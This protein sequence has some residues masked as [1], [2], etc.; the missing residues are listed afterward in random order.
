M[1]SMV[2]VSAKSRNGDAEPTEGL[3]DMKGTRVYL[4]EEQLIRER[5]VDIL[6]THFRL[7]GYR[8][9]ET[10]ILEFWDIA[11]SK[12]GGGSEIL[13]ETYKLSDQGKRDLALRYELT[14]KLGKV[15]GMNPEMRL[16]F[17]RYEIGK[18]FRDGPIKAGR[19][20]EFTQCDVDV[21]GIK[22]LSADAEL[23]AL[24]FQTFPVLGLEDIYM[25]LNNR[26]LLFGIF[27]YAV[28]PNEK[29]GEAALSL[30]KLAK[31]GEDK[32]RT[33]LFQKEISDQSL[34]KIFTLLKNTCQ[35]QSN[36]EKLDFLEATVTNETARSGTNELRQILKYVELMGVKGDLRLEPT[37]ARG[38][39]YYTGP[40]WEIYSKS[41]SIRSSL[42]AG[43]RWDNM[44]AQFI[45]TDKEYPATGMTFGLDVIYAVLEEKK[46]QG[47]L[48]TIDTIPTILI[49]PINTEDRSMT[50]ASELR[51][52]RI[53]CEVATTKK[54]K[55]AMELAGRSQ[56]PFVVIVGDRELETGSVNFRDMTSGK[57][58]LVKI[59]DL[60]SHVMKILRS[61]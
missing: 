31:M 13:K 6:R 11:A 3:R 7:Y 38:L 41:S 20:R 59:G 29:F 17:K 57:E 35:K 45:G 24:T 16:P 42:A 10:S 15:I 46:F 27:E 50:I 36:T 33:E 4:P 22:E 18:V 5:V 1:I 54:L 25:E 37:L 44:I 2:E 49:I 48:R 58:T 19:I 52:G 21:V 9:L 39:G 14:F 26:K 51:K 28:V 32:V 30:D 47:F 23:I 34:D 61:T 60:P 53:S 8:P 12:Y 43:G 56:I 55:K 40:M